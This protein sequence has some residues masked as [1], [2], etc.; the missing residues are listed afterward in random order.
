MDTQV[1][2]LYIAEYEQCETWIGGDVSGFSKYIRPYDH[3]I[4]YKTGRCA[5]PDRFS[6]VFSRLGDQC[7]I[8]DARDMPDADMYEHMLLMVDKY[9]TDDTQ[10]Y[11][12]CN[13]DFYQAIRGKVNKGCGISLIKHFRTGRYSPP[14]KS[15]KTGPG[16]QLEEDVA[17][18]KSTTD[19]EGADKDRNKKN[20][21][22]FKHEKDVTGDWEMQ[23]EEQEDDH[24]AEQPSDL[25][26]E[27]T[28]PASVPDKDIEKSPD[29]NSYDKKKEKRAKDRARQRDKKR[30]KKK[31]G[32]LQDAAMVMDSFVSTLSQVSVGAVDA[33]GPVT[34][35]NS[36]VIQ[37]EK[38]NYKEPD[39]K[40][41]SDGVPVFDSDVLIDD[42]HG[43]VPSHSLSVDEVTPHQK[44]TTTGLV[45]QGKE[46]QT[47]DDGKIPRPK[48]KWKERIVA[49]P[50]RKANDT[51][52]GPSLQDLEKQI[53]GVE[54]SY[55]E[56]E[57]VYTEL[58]DT[59]A[60]MVT[61]LGD[62][63]T[64]NIDLLIPQ[65]KKLGLDDDGYTELIAVLLKSYDFADF[66]ESYNT[67]H[68]GAG[69]EIKQREIAATQLAYKV[70]CQEA[71]Y[72]AK[73]CGDLYTDD[74]W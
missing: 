43:A 23:N 33:A 61:L 54:Q 22:T 73:I 52:S 67:L 2:R 11:V 53:F 34:E 32:D 47:N 19:M 45:D 31:G 70:V 59:K 21:E 17:A 16:P 72:Y 12:F 29:I 4:L 74:H 44:E 38:S 55:K 30:G 36:S 71:S 10:I 68:P 20:T 35:D 64:H 27:G 69:L 41:S 9:A 13:E 24:I 63:L 8:I 7:E 48:R 37:D 26:G 49:D 65:I 62:R 56:P 3:Y 46:D 15:K 50:D 40:G 28:T 1:Y 18:V 42:A 60:K 25:P 6:R 51:G 5:V 66:I 39:K 57:K 58:D 14:I